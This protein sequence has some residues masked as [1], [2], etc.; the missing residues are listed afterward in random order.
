MKPLEL[1]VPMTF[2]TDIDVGDTVSLFT[3]SV[4]LSGGEQYL[5][6]I[7]S[8]YNDILEREPEVLKTLAADWYWE[9]LF[10]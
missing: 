8:V 6:S 9:R 4:P 7:A 2:H 1:P 3:Q 10:R 5:A